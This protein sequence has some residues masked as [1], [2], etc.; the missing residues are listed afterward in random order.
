MKLFSKQEKKMEEE[1]K[2]L[3][4]KIKFGSLGHEFQSSKFKFLCLLKSKNYEFLNFTIGSQLFVSFKIYIKT[5][6]IF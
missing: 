3:F 6:L 1:M 4:T 2:F 5:I